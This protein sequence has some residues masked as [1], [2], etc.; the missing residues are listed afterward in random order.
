[1][2]NKKQ[3]GRHAG[4][5]GGRQ[6]EEEEG[7]RERLREERLKLEKDI[8]LFRH[9]QGQSTPVGKVGK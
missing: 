5:A 9:V 1:M 6:E 7:K 3:E 8:A 4:T 2:K